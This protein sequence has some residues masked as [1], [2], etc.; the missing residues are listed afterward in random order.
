M[1]SLEERVDFAWLFD[2]NWATEIIVAVLVNLCLGRLVKSYAQ[3][4]HKIAD[5]VELCLLAVLVLLLD[6]ELGVEV[7]WNT[8]DFLRH[9][10][11]L[12]SCHARH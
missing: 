1:R 9:F 6:L 10:T 8:F 12:A 2:G 4:I 11:F 5:F 7:E 3:L